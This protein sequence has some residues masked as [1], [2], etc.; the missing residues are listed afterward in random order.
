MPAPI[1]PDDLSRADWAE[2]VRAAGE[3]LRGLEAED[4]EKQRRDQ[5]A[6]L[7]P[8]AEGEREWDGKEVL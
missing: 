7:L 1:F 6:D 5:G 4:A 3:I 2:I 8:L